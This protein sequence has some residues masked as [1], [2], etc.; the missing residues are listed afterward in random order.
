MEWKALLIDDNENNR[1]LLTLLLDAAGVAVAIAEDGQSAL[2]IAHREKPDIILLDI[3]LSEMDGY[4]LAASLMRDA[5]LAHVPIIGVSSFPVAGDRDKAM[6]MGFAAY[7]EKPV[8]P[9]QFAETVIGILE[10]SGGP[11]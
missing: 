10:R 9:E 1:H 7:I 8:V 4:E 6:R 11:G 2:R 5:Q 3:Q